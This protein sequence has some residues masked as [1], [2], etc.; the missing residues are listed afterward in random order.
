MQDLLD[1][2]SADVGRP[3][4]DLAPKFRI[5]GSTEPPHEGLRA[6]TMAVL[7]NLTPQEAEVRSDS[8]RTYLLRTMPYRTTENHIEGVVVTFVDVTARFVAE[9]ALEKVQ[10][11]LQAALEQNPAALVIVEAGGGR[12]THVNR[13]AA[14][15]FAQPYPLPYL[16][17]TW[18]DL[19]RSLRGWSVEGR[20]LQAE[21]WPLARTRLSRYDG[22]ST[23]SAPRRAPV[24][25]SGG[26]IRDSTASSTGWC[27]PE[28]ISVPSS[29]M[30]SSTGT[31]AQWASSMTISV[32]PLRTV[33]S[34]WARSPMRLRLRRRGE[35]A[36]VGGPMSTNGRP[37]AALGDPTATRAGRVSDRRASTGAVSLAEQRVERTWA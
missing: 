29:S 2:I 32:G 10:R 5:S 7:E 19:V 26:T 24:T 6:M 16:N 31:W 12:V 34:W 33:M 3:L 20:E 1:L 28:L 9:Q 11:R 37:P 18:R 22:R 35:S 27:R 15:L 14:A 36:S 4:S 30:K 13:K 8:G 23:A 21:E 25:S 17:E